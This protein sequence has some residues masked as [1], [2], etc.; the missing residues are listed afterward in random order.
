MNRNKRYKLTDYCD[1]YRKYIILSDKE[2]FTV[3][4]KTLQNICLLS[5]ELLD[6]YANLKKDFENCFRENSCNKERLKTYFK[7]VDD[8]SYKNNILRE[9]FYKFNRIK[10]YVKKRK[11]EYNNSKNKEVINNIHYIKLIDDLLNILSENNDI[12]K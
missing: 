7:I 4:R 11:I 6:D 8:E 3:K 9:Y 12:N 5:L 10:D 2:V 1:N